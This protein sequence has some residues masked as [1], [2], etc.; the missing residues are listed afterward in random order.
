MKYSRRNSDNSPRTI[1]AKFDGQC[2]ETGVKIKKGESCLYYPGEKK[3][4]SHDSNTA[5]LYREA[6]ADEEILDNQMQQLN[7]WVGIYEIG[8]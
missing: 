8:R 1:N 4:Y 2:N 3:I 7:G 5:K 6:Q